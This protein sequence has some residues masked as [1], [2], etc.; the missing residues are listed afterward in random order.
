MKIGDKVHYIPYE[1]CDEKDYE[2]GIVKKIGFDSHL[3]WVVYHCADDWDNYMN[4]TAAVTA[5]DQLR[6]GWID[7]HDYEDGMV[8]WRETQD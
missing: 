4:Y 7:N 1:G 5:S 2:N 3:V 8:D 6:E